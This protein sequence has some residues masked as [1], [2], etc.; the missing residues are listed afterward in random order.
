MGPPAPQPS[1]GLI[2]VTGSVCVVETEPEHIPCFWEILKEHGLE[3][4]F[5]DPREVPDL[6]AFEAWYERQALFSLTG[7][8]GD[9]V[10]GGAYLD[11][12]APGE[13]ASV[14]IFKRRGL[15]HPD[16]LRAVVRDALPWIFDAFD[17]DK[18]VGITRATNRACID[19]LE[20][21]GLRVDGVLRHY[22]RVQGRWTDY[23]LASILREELE[24]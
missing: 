1:S 20:A 23:V 19:L 14:N 6:R 18:V 7:L 22:K 2:S 24:T 10:V 21:V 8:M 9:E 5:A 15:I 12:I 3:R 17:L 13:W 16:L 4:F 11:Y